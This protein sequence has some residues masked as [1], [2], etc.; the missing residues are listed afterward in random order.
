MGRTF[1]ALALTAL[2]G[3]Q[4]GALTLD[5]PARPL[6]ATV[7][8]PHSERVA[9]ASTENGMIFAL[10]ADPAKRR[11]VMAMSHDGG[12]R[13]MPAVAVSPEGAS[14][15]YRS[16]NG[17]S[18]FARGMQVYALWQQS[19]PEGGS[20]VVVARQARMGEP[21]APP[22]R[23]LDKPVTDRSFNGFS[24]MALGPKGELYVVWLDGRD[25]PDLPGTFALY[26]AKSTDQGQT[27]GKNTRVATGVCPCC[28]PSI[29]VDDD[30][31][32]YVAWRKVFDGDIRDIVLASSH[33]GG[34]TFSEP[35]KAGEDDWVLHACPDSGPS[36]QAKSGRV[37][38]AWFS[39]GKGQ[40]GIRYASSSDGGKSF[41]TMKI[42]SGSVV[43]PNH[44]AL[45]M[46]ANGAAVL[47]F[48]GRDAE[49]QNGWGLFATYAVRIDPAGKASVPQ[50]LAGGDGSSYP[51][52]IAPG[53]GK[54]VI[55]WT[56]G[57]EENASVMMLR[58]RM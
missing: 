23:V 43:D 26:M 47:A 28:R 56:K 58:A 27:F 52:A 9:L 55:A 14:V 3:C 4:R 53:L 30:G 25:R 33:D 31:T 49:A 22:V 18:L 54:A 46:D 38:V 19:R 37:A 24:S 40:S 48:Q 1:F 20:D 6:F 2:I 11:L 12:D 5:G 57:H 15:Q 7:G 10:A 44:P 8:V 35:R 42:V 21:F 51:T 13:F 17:P 16:E 32:V 45:A 39:E 29:A 41:S 34:V 36:L 50:P